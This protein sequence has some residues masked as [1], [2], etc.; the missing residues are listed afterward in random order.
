MSDLNLAKERASY[1]RL[2]ED[3]STE[4]MPME[5]FSGRGQHRD[6]MLRQGILIS[7]SVTP[8]LEEEILSVCQALAMP[9]Q[10][11]SAFVY[12]NPEIQADCLADTPD[13]CVLRFTSGLVSLLSSEE[14]RFVVGHELGHFLLGHGAHSLFLP[15]DTPETYMVM[16]SRELSCDRLGYVAAGGS[17]IALR[18][19]LKT[20]SGL[21]E[22]FIRFDVSS[23]ISQKDLLSD[24]SFGESAN[25]THPSMMI[26]C[27][28]LLWLALAMNNTS[29]PEQ[30]TKTELEKL[31]MRV[32]DDLRKF[33]DG[34]TRQ[35]QADLTKD[36]A[37]WKAA[38]FIVQSGSFSN[39][40][41]TK[42]ADVFGDETTQKLKAFFGLYSNSELRNEI[43]NRLEMAARSALDEFP[44][45]AEAIATSASDMAS[46][47]LD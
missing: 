2:P 21:G 7:E 13:T 30:L 10:S 29:Q 33:V 47:I 28:A 25:S 1:L 22:D 15:D 35:R 6:Q 42:M 4:T 38:A 18:A 23:V 36:I 26:R 46:S 31:N 41:Q 14:F 11:V 3:L 32:V 5:M 43:N 27:R 20:M 34:H 16:R 37:L 17:D 24:P 19:I 8:K 40:H 9:R 12:S 44:S 45:S 39:N